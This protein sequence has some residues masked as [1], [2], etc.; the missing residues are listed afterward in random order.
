MNRREFFNWAG[1]G[2]LAT[3]LPWVL[4][5]C[6]PQAPEEETASEDESSTASEDTTTAAAD[7]FVAVGTVAQLDTDGY[8]LD[9]DAS[10]IVVRDGEELM[11]LSPICPHKQ[12]KVNWQASSSQLVCPCHDSQFAVDGSV[13]Q[14][15]ATTPL[16]TYEVKESDESVLVKVG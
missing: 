3:Q 13:V 4:A 11:A 2:F 10:V 1:A 9:E 8:L 7:G 6:S 5:A 14:G 15:P 12:C 16:P